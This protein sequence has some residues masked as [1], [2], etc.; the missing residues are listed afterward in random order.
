MTMAS[1]NQRRRSAGAGEGA[2]VV[3]VPGK[4]GASGTPGVTD[5]ADATVMVASVCGA[6]SGEGAE[7]GMGGT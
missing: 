4:T 2:S 5:V 7:E 3:G 1:A 6:A